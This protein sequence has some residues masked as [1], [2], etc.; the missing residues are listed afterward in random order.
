MKRTNCFYYVLV[1]VLFMCITACDKENSTIEENIPAIMKSDFSERYPSAKITTF[2]N[3]SDG[4]YQINFIDK[5]QNQAFIWYINETWGMT[6]T[7]INDIDQ[8]PPKTLST[9]QNSGY[10]DAQIID[11]YKTERVGIEK[12]LYTLHFKYSW[13]KIENMEHYVFIND[14]GLFLTTF[15]STPNDPSSIVKLPESHF[16]FIAEKYNGAEIRG[17][18]NN[19][20]AH[21]YFILHEGT[22]KYIFFGGETATDKG[23]WKETRYELSK[24]VEI[25]ANVVSVLKQNAP[26]FTYTNIYYIESDSGNKYLFQDKNHESELG[27]YIGE[28]IEPSEI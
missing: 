17:Y 6:Y 10:G 3:Y 22:I 5:E 18:I 12:G 16:D 27:Y 23:F 25:P 19:G 7:K 14:D 4:L 24:D 1:C 26:D 9:F 13:K 28:A 20:G 15:T 11:I 2:Q 21:E 8:L